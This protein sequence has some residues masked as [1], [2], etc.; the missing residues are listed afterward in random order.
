MIT[1]LIAALAII[2]L[3]GRA[4]DALR[5]AQIKSILDRLPEAE[6]RAYYGDLKGRLR[7]VAI[8]RAVALASLL[9][10]FYAFRHHL[11][12]HPRP[13]AKPASQRTLGDLRQLGVA[14]RDRVRLHAA[15]HLGLGDQRGNVGGGEPGAA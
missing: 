8:M 7:R 5:T 11:V 14:E 1:G 13:P 15:R 9:C 4:T 2:A 3:G 6:A 12:D 10:L